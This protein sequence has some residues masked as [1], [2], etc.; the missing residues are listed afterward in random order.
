MLKFF[1][2]ST[3]IFLSF[4]HVQEKWRELSHLILVFRNKSAVW[5]PESKR[6]RNLCKFI[7]NAVQLSR[8]VP[9]TGGTDKRVQD[10]AQ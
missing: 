8:A 2:V 7:C 9:T 10:A 3:L 1:Y 4:L 5:I 6:E